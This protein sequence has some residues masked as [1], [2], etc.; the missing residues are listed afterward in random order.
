MGQLGAEAQVAGDG[1]DGVVLLG[2]LT[3]V[4]VLAQYC[5]PLYS[6]LYCSP[7][8][9]AVVDHGVVQTSLNL[10]LL[11]SVLQVCTRLLPLPICLNLPDLIIYRFNKRGMLPSI[12][13]Y[14]N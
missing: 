7:I 8:T 5:W 13:I 3:L 12:R 4:P 1:V 10:Q 11:Q 6:L 14:R 2:D 9:I